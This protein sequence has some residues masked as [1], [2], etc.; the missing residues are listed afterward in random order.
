M[1]KSFIEDQREVARERIE[2]FCFEDIF[3]DAGEKEFDD[4]FSETITQIIT[5]VGE[6]LMRLAEGELVMEHRGIPSDCEYNKAIDTIKQHIANVTG[7]D[8]K[9]TNATTR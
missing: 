6:E 8:P 2:E 3:S 9:N 7:V 5:N 4:L 1:K